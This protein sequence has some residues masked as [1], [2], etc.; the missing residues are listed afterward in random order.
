[1]PSAVLAKESNTNSKFQLGRR[2]GRHAAFPCASM[3]SPPPAPRLPHRRCPARP[4]SLSFAS[5]SHRTL[6]PQ[7]LGAPTVPHC[8]IFTFPMNGYSSTFLE[9]G[10]AQYQ[11]EGL[12]Q[13]PLKPVCW[14]TDTTGHRGPGARRLEKGNKRDTIVTESA[15]SVNSRLGLSRSQNVVFCRA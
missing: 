10:N 1:M 11:Q 3:L 2:S 14:Q 4:G 15:G 5:S 12:S 7:A 8:V 9:R 13:V 6:A